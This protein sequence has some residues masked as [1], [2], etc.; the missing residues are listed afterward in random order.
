M[1]SGETSGAEGSHTEE[2]ENYFV[3]MTDMIVGILFIFIIMLMIFAFN[4]QKQTD[5]TEALT[6]QQ[7]LQIEKAQEL[8]Q[9][10][11]DLQAQID[12]EISKIDQ[13]DQARAELLET[14]RARLESVG[15]KV[16]IDR[17]TGVLRLNDDAIRFEK[18]KDTLNRIAEHNVD[19]LARV[20]A[21]VLPAYTA[22]TTATVCPTTSG[23]RIETVFV[24]GHTD[25]DGGRALN[26]QLSTARA[27]NTYGRIVAQSPGLLT[28]KNSAGQEILSVSGYA[29]TRPVADPDDLEANRRIDLRFVMEADRAKRLSEVLRLLGDMRQRVDAL[30][31]AA[32]FGEAEQGQSPG[33]GK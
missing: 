2:D 33:P 8:A 12:S 14:I 3:S 7:K 9:Q 31:E 29:D 13:A 15:L 26:W 16:T 1:I 27:V 20:L 5:Q 11:S 21:D 23:H 32:G 18:S 22:C 6:E 19:S 17:E 4:F 10:I 30:E 28:L 24:E 25:R